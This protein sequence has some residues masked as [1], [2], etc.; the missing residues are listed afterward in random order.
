MDLKFSKEGSFGDASPQTRHNRERD[1]KQCLF[2]SVC[3]SLKFFSQKATT[4]PFYLSLISQWCGLSE[5]GMN[6]LSWTSSSIA[7]TSTFKRQKRVFVG[8]VRKWTAATLND[9]STVSVFW[10]DNFSKIKSMALSQTISDRPYH[11]RN[12]TVCAFTSCKSFS[13]RDIRAAFAQPAPLFDRGVFAA[14]QFENFCDALFEFVGPV[15]PSSRNYWFCFQQLDVSEAL[16]DEMD[17]DTLETFKELSGVSVGMENFFPVDVYTHN[18]GDLAGTLSSIRDARMLR[19]LHHPQG[20]EM[21]V[22][23]DVA[24]F[25]K[26]LKFYCSGS[27][28]GSLLQQSVFPV[29][30]PWHPLR[31]SHKVLFTNSSFFLDPLLRSMY[32]KQKDG[33]PFSFVTAKQVSLHLD[34][35]VF[36]ESDAE[37]I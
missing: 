29:L 17:T 5:R 32:P 10:I 33:Q 24:F 27:S 20:K 31:H 36:C 18:P 13:E 2:E 8:K 21:F 9:D 37:G 16:L 19:D 35:S 7:P 14:D 34:D 28:G 30:A 12:T 22:T 1:M 11:I 4:L 6:F 23:C 26:I 15:R 3:T 25:W